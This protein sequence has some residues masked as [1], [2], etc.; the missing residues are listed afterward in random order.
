MQRGPDGELIAQPKHFT[1]TCET[2]G[3]MVV[4]KT[5]SGKTTLIRHVLS[6]LD[7]L[8]TVSPDIQ[9][10]ISVEVPSNV[11]MKSLGIEVLDKLGYRIENQRSISE[12]EIWRIVRHRFRLKGTVLLWIDEAQDLFRTKGPATTRH[13]LNTIKNLM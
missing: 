5:G 9:P 8:Q 1:A 4:A 11:T 2:R 3:L 13:I 12:H 10:W 6:N 7:I